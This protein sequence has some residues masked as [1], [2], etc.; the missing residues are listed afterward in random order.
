MAQTLIEQHSY[1]LQ[2]NQDEQESRCVYFLKLTDSCLKAIEEHIAYRGPIR[3]KPNIKFDGQNG[4]I[5]I[6]S[7]PGSVNKDVGK[8]YS[9]TIASLGTNTV[10]C[11]KHGDKRSNNLSSFGALDTKI[12][13]AATEDVYENTRNRM[14]QVDQERKDVRTKEIKIASNTKQGKKA[15]AK[16]VQPPDNSSYN[17][18]AA[19]KK[20]LVSS[21]HNKNSPKPALSSNHTNSP[22]TNLSSTHTNSPK[23]PIYNSSSP[24]STTNRSS[25]IT[26][27]KSFSCRERVIH[28]LALRPH[29]KP[30]LVTRLQREAMS[31]KD[32]N[33]LA[34]VLQ[35]VGTMSDNQYKLQTNLYSEVNVDTWPF[36]NE[37]ERLIVKRNIATHK[38]TIDTSSPQLVSSTSKSPEEKVASGTKRPTTTSNTVDST[39]VKRMKHEQAHHSKHEQS[40]HTK[41]EQLHHTKHEQSHHTKHEQSQ[42]T[43]HEE[44]SSTTTNKRIKA[45]YSSP[46]KERE[47]ER[48][49]ER[50][51][52]PVRQEESPPTVASTSDTPEHLVTYKPI[53]SY[54]Q[55]CQY[56]RDFQSEYPEYIEL[57]KNVDAVTS[58]FIELDA[59]WRR[60]EKGTKEY[61]KLQDEIVDAYNKQQKD[62]K[63][64]EMKRRCQELHQKLFHIK[65]LVVEY[66]TANLSTT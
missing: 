46:K 32:R 36:Y 31:Q 18:I 21:H 6:P 13:I 41:H 58:K 55:R 63:F 15:K 11:I 16:L 65:R 26:V 5:T 43:K 17:Q 48:E 7:K 2:T 60:T 50:S 33:N 12:N 23:P 57:K 45:D 38:K 40:H 66:D 1:N 27:N 51:K 22:K 24:A 42:H 64:H 52:Q 56:K 20:K 37:S 39:T 8:K 3:L 4:L 59:S 61:E 54:E 9:F 10:D 29:K 30:E 47:K 35:Q 14:A 28:V 44:P 25:P 62:E 49:K 34:M 19:M 53:T